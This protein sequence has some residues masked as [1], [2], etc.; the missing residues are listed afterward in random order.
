MLR[1]RIRDP[2]P[3]LFDPWSRDPGTG[4]GFFQ[5]PDLGSQTKILESLVTIFWVKKFSNSLKIGPNF[6]LQH[7]KNKIIFNFVKFMATKKVP[8]MTTNFFHPLFCCCFWIRDPRFGM[9]KNQ[10]PGSGI[11]IPDPQHWMG[12]RHNFGENI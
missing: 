11:K 12:I 6:F 1:I 2:V 9:G 4:K 5:I 3:C 8:G 7:F 10:D